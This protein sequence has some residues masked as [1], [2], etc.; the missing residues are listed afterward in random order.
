MSRS[1]GVATGHPRCCI[2]GRLLCT[3]LV[4]LTAAVVPAVVVAN[5][6]G[7]EGMR[8]APVPLNSPM[9][10]Y[11]PA[12]E[13]H[14]LFF[15]RI[16]TTWFSTKIALSRPIR[17]FSINDP[18]RPISY[19]KRPSEAKQE[20]LRRLAAEVRD[21][22]R[23]AL[24]ALYGWPVHVL[25]RSQTMSDEFGRSVRAWRYDGS[26]VAGI[27]I[28]PRL[29]LDGVAINAAFNCVIIGGIWLTAQLVVHWRRR[30]SA[31]CEECG[32]STL[33]RDSRSGCCPECGA[34]LSHAIGEEQ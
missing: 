3:A 23:Y 24:F 9:L 5:V 19:Y 8:L 29:K 4:G 14:M 30:V 33:A 10:G 18:S 21:D 25:Q 13:P 26:E 2:A 17:H 20:R 12:D 32:Y 7:V 1:S 16:E 6:Q 22:E 28:P 11:Q 34:D 27:W 15:G 31:E